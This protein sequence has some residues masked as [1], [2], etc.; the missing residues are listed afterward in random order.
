MTGSY[1]TALVVFSV[2]IAILASYTALVLAAR[3]SQASGRFRTA[4]LAGGSVSLGIGVWSMHFVGMLAFRLDT[5]ITYDVPRWI[6]SMVVAVGASL[7]TLWVAGRPRVTTP[8]LAGASLLMGAGIAAMH[9]LGMA[10]MRIHGTIRYDSVR[11]VESLGVAVAASFAAL[12]LAL[13]FRADDTRRGQAAK[14]AAAVVMGLAIAGMHYTGMSAARFHTLPGDAPVPDDHVLRTDGLASGVVLG[15]LVVLGITLLTTMVDRRMRARTAEAE[16]AR[17]SEARFRSLV[18]AS[19][20]VVF[21]TGPDGAVVTPQRQWA[22]YTGME[23]EQYRGWGWL[24]AVHPDERE[25][26]AALW[27]DAVADRR[28]IDAEH[29]VMRADGEWRTLALRAVPVLEEDGGIREWVGAA[30]DVTERRKSEAGRDLLAEASRVLVSSLEFETTLASVARL[31]VPALADWCA[32]DMLTLDGGMERLA[33]EHADP[34][35]IRLVAEIEERWPTSMNAPHGVARVLRTG[36]AE[37]VPDIPDALLTA[38]SHGPEH[39][40]AVRAL[41]L[42]SYV[43]VPL[44]ARGKVLGA[45]SLVYAESGRRYGPDDLALADEVARR[46]GTALA[47]ARL[48]AAERAALRRATALQQVAGSLAGALTPLEVARLVVHHGREA[49]GA[50]AGSLALLH[51]DAAGGPEF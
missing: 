1:N 16:A 43:C 42:R 10:A 35:K 46:V 25:H 14:A 40:A 26:A 39:L 3:V 44:I 48:Y 51:A 27:R 2:V 41:G 6:A 17:R 36:E 5:S 29:R 24:N 49:V 50:T 7:L 4:W 19:A 23:W 9:Y 11:V 38:N 8:M 15:T 28:E 37:I 32:I 13:R 34:A 45:L 30:T 22:G 31:A 47:A 21:T 33:V 20:Q 12:W 18:T